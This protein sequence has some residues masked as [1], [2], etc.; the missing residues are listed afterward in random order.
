MKKYLAIFII[1]CLMFSG[2]FST[3]LGQNE[4]DSL[5]TEIGA[6]LN[7]EVNEEKYVSSASKYAQTPDEAPSSISIITNQEIKAYDY[8]NLAQLL[9]AQKGIYYSD[10]KSA[11]HLGFRGFGSNSNNRV[12]LLLD[13]HRLNP[14]QIDYAP[15]LSLGLD[16]SNFEKVE[17][18]RGPGSTLYGS[19]AVHGVINLISKKERDSF[20][21][22]ISAKYGSNNSRYFG[23]RGYK[24]ISEDFSISIFGNYYNTDGEN[25]YFKEFD[26]INTNNGEVKNLDGVEYSGLM[27][28]LIFNNLSATILSSKYKKNVPT[29][30]HSTE[31][32]SPQSRFTNSSFVDI[33]WSSELSYDK[34]IFI[35]FSY[36]KSEYGSSLPFIFIPDDIE[37][38]GETN[39]I[40]TNT[41]FI[42]DILPNNR[43]ITGVE[44]RD[45]FDSK[46]KGKIKELNLI[47]DTWSYKLF[48]LYFQNEFQY[49][50][51][52]S[53]YFGLRRDDFFGQEVMLNPRA[54]LVYSPFEK[55]T[56]KF[57]FG[58]SFRAP[59][60]VERNLEEKN[61]A[62]FKSNESLKSELIKTTEIIWNYSITKN[63][64]SSFSIYNYVMTNLIKQVEDPIDDLLQYVNIGEVSA[65]G[66]EGEL[67]FY[68][69]Q[70]SGYLNY[71]YQS[72]KDKNGEKLVNS[73]EH[74]LKFGTRS[75]IYGMLNGSIEGVYESQRLTLGKTYSSP[76]FLIN[77][78]FYTDR[79]LE[80]FT[81]SFSV[82]NLLNYTIKHPT[83]H[84]F[85]QN[86]IVQPYRNFLFTI[87]ID[88]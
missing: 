47:D 59:N 66:V 79:I 11:L 23:V 22:A 67:N 50:A 37:F 85:V 76:N 48:S 10:D 29:A 33:N 69:H 46:Y 25:F 77:T 4:E 24:K 82:K 35:N 74:L 13:G 86:S 63:L 84:E 20:L 54:G 15:I 71:S 26:D 28:K 2:S 68:F 83:S 6:I 27:A 80:Y 14:Y 58:Q 73:P 51:T 61:I 39:T 21:P 60:L 45:N 32:N 44:Y 30:P 65:N 31:F 78:N 17:I 18:V 34:Q 87:S 55:H 36:D 38:L 56:F 19:N 70:G 3:L 8:Q 40:G 49:D 43:L 53:L 81:F 16:L 5:V 41:Q 9:N 57:L 72:A 75:K 52:L 1:V 42:W 12:L 88:F 64:E 62:G 7:L